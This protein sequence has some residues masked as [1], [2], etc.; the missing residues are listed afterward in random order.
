MNKWIL[1]LVFVLIGFG[2]KA[3]QGLALKAGKGFWGDV[4]QL[5]SPGYGWEDDEL[6]SNP[7]VYGK[8]FTGSITWMEASYKMNTGYAVALFL[9]NGNTSQHY[10]DYLGFFWEKQYYYVYNFYSITFLRDFQLKK[11][12]FSPGA[13][14]SY[15][16]LKE[17]YADYSIR[18]NGDELMYSWP[19]V[20][21][22]EFNDLG[23]ELKFDYQYSFTEN[24]SLGLRCM[25]NITLAIG[26]EN[27]M[28]SPFLSLRIK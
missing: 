24:L 16:S 19:G 6:S 27:L 23:I 21:N 17:S 4:L 18:Y 22:S 12:I 28:V 5:L 2:A 26:L 13:G 10:N 7:E 8:M 15:R 11:H 14:V 3:Q 9:G 1:G 20:V 25:G